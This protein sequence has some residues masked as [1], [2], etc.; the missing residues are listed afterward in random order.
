MRLRQVA[1]VAQELGPVTDDLCAVFG[2]EVSWNDPGLIAF[3]LS[4]VILPIGDTFLEVVTP[5]QAGTTAGRLLEKRNGDGGY[6][7]IVQTED[8]DVERARMQE[9]GVRVVW[10]VAHDDAATIHL[11]PKDVGAAIVSLDTANPPDSW[12]W[13]GPGWRQKV[14]TD[15]VSE[16]VGVEV[17]AGDPESGAHRWADVFGKDVACTDDGRYKI[18][19]DQGSIWFGA[20]EDDRGDGVVGFV[21]QATDAGAA[22]AAAKDRGLETGEDFVNLCGMRFRLA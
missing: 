2:L 7:V 8:L 9:L 1:A 11:H 5:V 21:L 6:M 10:S 15:R 22:L 17:Q 20:S 19:L 4:N 18:A 13:A 12:R 3:G 16:I 14:R